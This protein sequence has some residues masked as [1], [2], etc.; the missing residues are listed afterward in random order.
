MEPHQS[1][2]VAND[3]VRRLTASYELD[4]GKLVARRWLG[5]KACQHDGL[6]A[7]SAPRGHLFL[8]DESRE[9]LWRDGVCNP[10]PNVWGARRKRHRYGYQEDPERSG[11]GE[12]PVRPEF[13]PAGRSRASGG[14]GSDAIGSIPSGTM[15]GSHPAS[16]TFITILSNTATSRRSRPGPTPPFTDR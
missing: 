9:S 12:C 5:R 2:E 4:N 7:V 3:A 16:T 14:S 8:Y 15:P 10:V 11:R 6:S 1:R 13:R